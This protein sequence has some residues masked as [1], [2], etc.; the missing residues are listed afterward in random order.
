M[1]WH[2]GRLL[3]S[4]RR[5]TYPTPF[6]ANTPKVSARWLDTLFNKKFMITIIFILSAV[7]A[8][9]AIA[10][11]VTSLVRA[12][13]GFESEQGFHFG[14]PDTPRSSNPIGVRRLKKHAVH[15]PASAAVASH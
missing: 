14:T 8:A 12:E 2:I 6:P 1:F 11:F 10:V 4:T 7:I 9:P 3:A 15:A 5:D 13:E